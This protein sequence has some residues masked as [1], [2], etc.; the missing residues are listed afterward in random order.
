M[1]W[2]WGHSLARGTPRL[3]TTRAAGGSLV[4]S[5]SH[6]NISSCLFYWGSSLLLPD[7]LEPRLLA[8]L[9]PPLGRCIVECG[10]DCWSP[11]SEF[12]FSLQLNLQPWTCAGVRLGSPSPEH[13]SS[14]PDLWN[15]EMIS[16]SHLQL[17]KPGRGTTASECS[18][19]IGCVCGG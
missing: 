11:V 17:V 10:G 2:P 1:P 14:S 18:W 6:L 13:H 19:D 8:C 16:P 4:F 15:L 3:Y 12:L 5:P 7:R 9:G